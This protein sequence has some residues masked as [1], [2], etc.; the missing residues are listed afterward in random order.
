VTSRRRFLLSAA[1]FAG[2]GWLPAKSS[3]QTNS[4]GALLK[5]T[6]ARELFR[7]PHFLSGFHLMDP[8][9]GKRVV[10]GRLAAATDGAEL[11]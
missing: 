2:C 9:P 1:T 3:G 10:Y 8:K 5:R 6:T 7:D 11:A 4:G